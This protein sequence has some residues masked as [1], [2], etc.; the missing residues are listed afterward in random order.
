MPIGLVDF[1]GL[2]VQNWFPNSVRTGPKRSWWNSQTRSQ[3]ARERSR[4]IIRS[5]E[6][7]DRAI[8]LQLFRDN[9][10]WHVLQPLE[11]RTEKLLRRLRVA[12]ALHQDVEHGVVL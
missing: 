3:T 11:Q 2:P 4:N 12:P 7:R 8:A 5:P 6:V 1:Q 9:D 10:A